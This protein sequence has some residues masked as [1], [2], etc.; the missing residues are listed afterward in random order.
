VTGREVRR[1]GSIEIRAGRDP[2][3]RPCVVVQYPGQWLTLRPADAR[4]LA[5]ALLDAA[6]E[7]DS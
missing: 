4:V 5:A 6:D 1:I 7:A 3:S 2:D